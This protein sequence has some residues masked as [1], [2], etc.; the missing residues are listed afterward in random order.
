MRMEP[1]VRSGKTRFFSYVGMGKPLAHEAI[2]G[3]CIHSRG[4][5]ALVHMATVLKYFFDRPVHIVVNDCVS[6]DA[7][8]PFSSCFDSF[9]DY[10]AESDLLKPIKFS[11][12]VD[13]LNFGT[14]CL[15]EDGTA[16]ERVL[17][18]WTGQGLHNTRLGFFPA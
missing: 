17:L 13:D 15:S 7:K 18:E 12:L 3:L 5:G 4:T 6:S 11:T 1:S 14:P 2:L 16:E 8:I 10:C 9:K